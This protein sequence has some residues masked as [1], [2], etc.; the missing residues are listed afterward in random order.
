MSENGISIDS[1][2]ISSV[3]DWP[4]PTTGRQ[5]E[6]YL[7]LINY[8]RDFIPI[9]STIAAPLECLRKHTSLP[10]EKWSQHQLDSFNLLKNIL[11]QA[12]FL[13]FPNFR[14]P[15]IIATDASDAGIGAVLYQ[16]KDPCSP[17]TVQNRKW[18]MFSARALNSSERNYSATKREL[19]AIVFALGKFHY[20][21]WGSHFDLFTDHRALTVHLQP[22][23]S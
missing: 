18:V 23:K 2:K 4:I 9:Y 1:R 15:F 21:I 17:D 13:S 19:L 20:Y 8:F 22:E 6:Q 16:L 10:V 11:T 14:E 7:G 12:P 3:V 5:I